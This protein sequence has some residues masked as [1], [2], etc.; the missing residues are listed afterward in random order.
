MGIKKNPIKN[1]QQLYLENNNLTI[2]ISC[3]VKIARMNFHETL[4]ICRFKKK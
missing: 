2:S 4:L 3:N 1:N